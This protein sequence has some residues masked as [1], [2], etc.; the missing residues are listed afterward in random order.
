MY[1]PHVTP[2]ERERRGSIPRRGTKLYAIVCSG[3]SPGAKAC[4]AA[5]ALRAFA[6]AYPFIEAAWWRHSNTLVLLEAD[7]AA[8]HALEAR[9]SAEGVSCVRFVEPDWAPEGTL[10][11][12]VVGPEGRRLVSSLPLAFR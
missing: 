4:Q 1:R 11:A 8:L 2:D 9:A 12:L 3:L 7:E 10:T 5:H 6:D